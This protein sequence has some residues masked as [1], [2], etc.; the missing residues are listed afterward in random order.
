MSFRQKH[1]KT[2]LV[3]IPGGVMWE[4]I[5]LSSVS[6]GFVIGAVDL[7]E[8]YFHWLFPQLWAWHLLFLKRTLPFFL[9][10][11]TPQPLRF[12]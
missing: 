2:C 9:M 10:F 12:S 8:S 1:S 7:F 4:V 3:L 11:P 5:L 6:V